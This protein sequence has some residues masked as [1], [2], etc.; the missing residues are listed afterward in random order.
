MNFCKLEENNLLLRE[1]T[2]NDIQLIREWRNQDYIRKYFINNDYI[3]KQQ[4]QEW[5]QKYLNTNNDIMFVIEETIE[6]QKAIGTVALYNI[7]SEKKNTE[8]GRLMIGYLPAYGKGF[9]KRAAILACKYAFEI[10]NMREIHL[11]VLS[12]NFKAIQLYQEIGFATNKIDSNQI[13]MVLNRETYF[14]QH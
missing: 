3:S 13:Y 8:F 6:L 9:G 5:F 14:N 4:Q 7:N 11:N 2:E 1:I 10:L 12:C